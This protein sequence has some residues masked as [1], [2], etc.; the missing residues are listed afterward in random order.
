MHT[1]T[2]TY[3]RTYNVTYCARVCVDAPARIV[4][5]FARDSATCE[6]EKSKSSLRYNTYVVCSPAVRNIICMYVV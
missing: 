1:H 2:Q 3:S 6:S 5:R 4:L